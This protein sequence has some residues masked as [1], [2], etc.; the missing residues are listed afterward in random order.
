M[1]DGPEP[2]RRIV[3]GASMA[4]LLGRARAA[5]PLRIGT[6]LN[7]PPFSS[8]DASGTWSGFNI[9]LGKAI[10]ARLARPCV[11]AGMR[12]DALIPALLG[13]RVDAVLAEVT[14]TPARSAEV[15]FTR[16]VTAAGGMLIVPE[17]SSITNDPARMRGK[18]I[19][20]QEGTTHEAYARAVL[21]RTAALRFYTTQ[22]DAFADLLAGRIDATLCD[23]E[24]GHA[25]LEEHAGAFRFADQPITDRTYYGAGTAIAVRPGDDRLRAELDHAIVS[26]FADGTFATI[27]RRYFSFSIAPDSFGDPL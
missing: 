12:F 10:C 16:P 22:D 4:L 27:D 6:E 19:G 20:V 18:V 25:W 15:L 7:N 14:V 1:R 9:D 24:L 23:M 13:R 26:V 8:L 5:E 2:G 21:A 11:W 17:M 3:L